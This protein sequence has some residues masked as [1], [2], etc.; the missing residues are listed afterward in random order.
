MSLR[1][2]LTALGV[3]LGCGWLYWEAKNRPLQRQ[4]CVLVTVRESRF[5]TLPSPLRDR[6]HAQ[7]RQLREDNMSPED[8]ARAGLASGNPEAWAAAYRI[9]RRRA[10]DPE[11]LFRSNV[12]RDAAAVAGNP[13]YWVL[14]ANAA[15]FLAWRVARTPR[16]VG[17]MSRCDCAPFCLAH[18]TF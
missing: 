4:L 14:G 12:V 1:V 10:L 8:A 18:H 16:L 17:F 6:I 9:A 13:L 11:P 15:V 3:S 5:P 7:E 2:G